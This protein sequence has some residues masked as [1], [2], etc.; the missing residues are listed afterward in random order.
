MNPY[1]KVQNVE[2]LTDKQ[3]RVTFS[4][5][6]A[7]VYDCRP[8]LERP[9]FAPLQDDAF[10]RNVRADPHGYGVVWNDD[11]DLS[12]SELWIHGTSE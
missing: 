7:K 11:L 6:S 8:L 2:P 10:F 1:P 9:P 4:T 3:L 12:E 5:G